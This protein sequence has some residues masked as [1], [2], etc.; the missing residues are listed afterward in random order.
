MPCMYTLS[1]Y[2][3]SNIS[4][5]ALTGLCTTSPAVMRKIRS[6][7]RGRIMAVMKHRWE[8]DDEDTGVVMVDYTLTHSTADIFTHPHSSLTT[9]QFLILKFYLTRSSEVKCRDR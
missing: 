9:P 6:G 5:N 3:F 8:N 1:S 7:A 2:L 4:F